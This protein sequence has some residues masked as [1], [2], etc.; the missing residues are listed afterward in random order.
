M[1]PYTW[2]L[3]MLFIDTVQDF[4]RRAY[5]KDTDSDRDGFSTFIIW[6]IGLITL[7]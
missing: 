3:V 1:N 6:I 4:I 5:P 7:T 2:T